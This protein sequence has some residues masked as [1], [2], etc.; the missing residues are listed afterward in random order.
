MV[1]TLVMVRLDKEEKILRILK[2]DERG[3]RATGEVNRSQGI[4]ENT[5]YT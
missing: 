2:E 4:S 1:D 5:Y 3:D